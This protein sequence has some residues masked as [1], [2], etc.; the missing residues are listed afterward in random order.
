MPEGEIAVDDPRAA[1]VVALLEQ[2]LALMRSITP[3]EHVHALDLTGLLDPAV[4][5]FSYRRDGELL[6]VGALKQLDGEHAE[7]KSMHTT[8][9]ARGR[10]IG[11]AMV[12]HLVG[13]ARAR[14]CDRV[15]LETGTH[16]AFAP[17]RS[18]YAGAGFRPCG[19][20]G[21]YRPSPSNTFMTLT[22]DGPGRTPP[23][24]CRAGS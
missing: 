13:V 4:T 10:G 20:F 17:A 3:P 19:P 8:R 12:D 15:S 23:S 14:G 1:D 22:L 5:F 9:A 6:A 21:S 11:R 24:G 7:I 16:D 2:H 18:L